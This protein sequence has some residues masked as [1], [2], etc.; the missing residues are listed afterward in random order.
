MLARSRSG[1]AG[2]LPASGT[3]GSAYLAFTLANTA[4]LSAVESK[5]R[6]V[7]LRQRD[8]YIVLALFPN[9]LTMNKVFAQLL[10]DLAANNLPKAVMVLLNSLDHRLYLS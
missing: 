9:Q 3:Y 10:F 8:A 7:D 5:M 6:N 1:A 4:H 2:I